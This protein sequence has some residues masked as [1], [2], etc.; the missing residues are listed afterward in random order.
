MAQFRTMGSCF[1]QDMIINLVTGTLRRKYVTTALTY[2]DLQMLDC[3]AFEAI[4]TSGVFPKTFGVVRRAATK[5]LFKMYFLDYVT[6]SQDDVVD[7]VKTSTYGQVVHQMIVIGKERNSTIATKT[8]RDPS[9]K[10]AEASRE[11]KGLSA[12]SEDG[13]RRVTELSTRIMSLERD[14]KMIKAYIIGGASEGA[15]GGAA[16]PA[17]APVKVKG[18]GGVIKNEDD[19]DVED[20]E[21]IATKHSSQSG[22]RVQA[23]EERMDRLQTFV[24]VSREGN[25]GLDTTM[26][27]GAE[28]DDLEKKQQKLRGKIKK[29]IR[30]F[31]ETQVKKEQSR[32][33]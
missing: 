27:M 26:D 6:S 28:I 25:K 17:G 22:M 7:M 2:S 16:G 31:N 19:L 4:I 13:A 24:A 20:F 10:L 8:L 33:P 23:L 1:G 18:K 12:Q 11:I 14:M 9:E 29:D 15:K 30:A 21:E 5:M 32:N 3:D